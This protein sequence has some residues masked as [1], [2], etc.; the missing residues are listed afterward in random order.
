M[1]WSSAP[2]SETFLQFTK[3]VSSGRPCSAMYADM[4]SQNL[5]AVAVF[6]VPTPPVR[7]AEHARLSPASGRNSVSSLAICSSRCTRFLGT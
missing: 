5:R 3:T 1:I 6:P 7:K 2:A 4:S